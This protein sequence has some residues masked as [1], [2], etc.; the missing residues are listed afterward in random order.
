MIL[1]IS[2]PAPKKEK[3]SYITLDFASKGAF[4]HND[5]GKLIGN[6]PITQTSVFGRLG[7]TL[8]RPLHDKL[9]PRPYVDNLSA[10]EVDIL[11]W[12]VSLLR[13]W[14]FGNLF[15]Q[16]APSLGGSIH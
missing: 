14:H 8:L 5:L 7:G 10:D 9:K 12:W 11:R 13:G 3:C 6:V 1:M 15:P 4:P 16:I 2:L